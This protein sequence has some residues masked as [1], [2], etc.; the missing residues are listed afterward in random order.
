MII[1][2]AQA[3]LLA[4]AGAR[5]LDSL[6][7][8]AVAYLRLASYY[9][10]GPL[11]LAVSGYWGPMLSWLIA[12]GMALGLSDLAAARAAMGLSA[13]AFTGA[14]A[15]CLGRLKAGAKAQAAGTVL[16]AAASVWWSV[17]YIAPDLLAAAWALAALGLAAEGTWLRRAPK[18]F[19]IGAAWGGAYLAKAPGL[20]L[21]GL[22]LGILAWRRLRSGERFSGAAR[23]F[24]AL[25]VGLGLTA[26]PWAAALSAKYGRLTI[27]TAAAAA[28]AIAGLNAAGGDHPFGRMLHRP[29]P[30]RVTSWEDP[31]SLPYPYWTPWES[32]AHLRRQAA[33]CA[34][35][36]L[37]EARLFFGFDLAGLGL[38]GLAAAAAFA[39]RARRGGGEA[40][41]IAPWLVAA[42]AALYLPGYL[43]PYDQRY[44][45]ALYPLLWLCAWEAAACLGRVAP[46]RAPLLAKALQPLVFGSFLLKAALGW[47]PALGGGP[48]P[49]TLAAKG[50]WGRAGRAPFPMGG[51]RRAMDRPAPGAKRSRRLARE[52]RGGRN[53]SS[54]N[55]LAGRPG[56]LEASTGDLPRERRLRRSSG[57]FAREVAPR[58]VRAKL[59]HARSRAFCIQKGHME[60]AQGGE[61][62]GVRPRPSCGNAAPARRGRAGPLDCR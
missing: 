26:G 42:G 20:I 43:G 12:G 4:W 36:I 27:S 14:A 39:A 8:D 15:F 6:N 5:R 35:N 30:G 50:A 32:R 16:A 40:G 52:R 28:H 22:W 49:A 60:P 17:E 29:E 21:V 45:Y 1:F 59:G 11:S 18:A 47:I 53:R 48:D 25:A 41:L 2:P 58:A 10:H 24:L 51:V 37:L 62:S 61:G 33:V 57:G 19:A 55:C 56:L 46:A 34:R 13:L 54:C 3:A 7:T 44:F 31:T 23:S 38:I 9:V